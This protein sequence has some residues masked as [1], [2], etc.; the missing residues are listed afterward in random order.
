MK[1]L[2]RAW[3]V[4]R[5]VWAITGVSV[6]VIFVAWSLIAFRASDEALA[7]AQSDGIVVVERA[8]GVWRFEPATAG[9]ASMAGGALTAPVAPV[10]PVAPGSPTLVFFPGALVDPRA[11]APLARAV[12]GGNHSQFGWYGFQPMEVE[13]R[14]TPPEGLPAGRACG[15]LSC[16]PPRSLPRRTARATP[17]T[18]SV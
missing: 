17:R 1:R 15:W 4:I 11:Y 3:P 13:V 6:T 16:S 14:A 7:A 5:R 9:A 10:A 8:D 2:R 18:R 12:A